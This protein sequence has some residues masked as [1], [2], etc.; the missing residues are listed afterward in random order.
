MTEQLNFTPFLDDGSRKRKAEDVLERISRDESTAHFLASVAASRLDQS[1]ALLQPNLQNTNALILQNLISLQSTWLANSLI[2]RSMVGNSSAFR[3]FATPRPPLTSGLESPAASNDAM[4]NLLLQQIQSSS[5]SN[6]SDSIPQLKFPANNQSQS[7]ANSISLGS[8]D[9]MNFG[10]LPPL[11]QLH[12]VLAPSVKMPSRSSVPFQLSSDSQSPL[13]VNISRTNS[14]S[15]SSGNGGP[16]TFS[17]ELGPMAVRKTMFEAEGITSSQLDS[18]SGLNRAKQ[19]RFGD[20]PQITS[21]VKAA[22][23][24]KVEESEKKSRHSKYCHFCQH[25]K[26]SM[27]ACGNPQCTFKFCRHCLSVHLQG[28]W[29]DSVRLA[30]QGAWACPCW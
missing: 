14:S 10:T 18:P 4:L 16:S 15:L 9:S 19:A 27:L 29:D 6:P 26:S 25:I 11:H 7:L 21:S 28:D 5:A 22:A 13:A 23:D 24:G 3:P 17:L 1:A 30:R 20:V 2:Q 8:N 12:S